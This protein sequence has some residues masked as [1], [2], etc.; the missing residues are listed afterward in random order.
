VVNLAEETF[1]V[2]T[3]PC[4]WGSDRQAVLERKRAQ[5]FFDTPH[6]LTSSLRRHAAQREEEQVLFAALPRF[7]LLDALLQSLRAS[8]VALD[9][10]YSI[11]L[12]TGN[13]CR[14]L[15]LP[16]EHC[17]VLTRHPDGLRESLVMN[18]Q[19]VFSRLAALEDA[20]YGD[21]NGVIVAEAEKLRR[22]LIGQRLIE[23]DDVLTVCPLMRIPATEKIMDA[24]EDNLRFMPVDLNVAAA[25]LGFKQEV[26]DHY[27]DGLFLHL[28]A[29][30]PPKS[31]FAPADL[32]DE[33]WFIRLRL[34]FVAAGVVVLL[35]GLL[36]LGREWRVVQRLE[37]ETSLIQAELTS[38][39]AQQDAQQPAPTHGLEPETLRFLLARYHRLARRPA[40]PRLKE[41]GQA[42]DDMP[43]VRL[44]Q[45]HW[46]CDTEQSLTVDGRLTA[47]PPRQL[48]ARFEALQQRLGQRG[49]RVEV[50]THPVNTASD[51]ALQGIDQ[52]DAEKG[53][54]SDPIFRL[55]LAWEEKS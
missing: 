43:D 3:I 46:R 31:Q 15:R 11:P 44:D 22:Y 38:L 45:L 47:A 4:L 5:H 42:L 19:T 9:G 21:M 6:V 10:L 28:A 53:K 49:V 17:L 24:R 2:E 14:A 32:R 29:T 20:D 25:R 39:Q 30:A 34:G 51:Q 33:R 35:A 23:R 52:N 18:G 54:T 7:A 27:A 13:L 50:L 48:V 26:E 12:V 8:R 16:L 1:R 36:F 37:A 40:C 41:L 55:R